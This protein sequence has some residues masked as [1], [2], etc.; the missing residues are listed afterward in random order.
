MKPLGV[1]EIGGI[2]TLFRHFVHGLHP[3]L[4]EIGKSP[5]KYS[6][7]CRPAGEEEQVQWRGRKSTYTF[8]STSPMKQKP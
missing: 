2:Y 7:R 3:E 4:K 6:L 8:S 5:I 1:K